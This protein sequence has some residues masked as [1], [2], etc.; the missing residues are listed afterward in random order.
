MERER[1]RERRRERREEV[2]EY[3]DEEGGEG[4]I[5]GWRGRGKRLED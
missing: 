3:N 1:G 2:E 5:R 4:R